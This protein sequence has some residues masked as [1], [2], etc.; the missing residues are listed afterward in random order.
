MRGGTRDGRTPNLSAVPLPPGPSAGGDHVIKWTDKWAERLLHD[1]GREQWG[2]KWR[3]EFSQGAGSKNGEVWDVTA[4]GH[5]YQRWWGEDHH[6]DGRVR[7]HGHSTGGEWWDDTI[8]MD[9]YYNPIPHFGYKH[10]LDHSPQLKRVP[11]RPK[12]WP[13]PAGG[14]AAT[15]ADD[16]PFG[17]GLDDL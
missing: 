11:L 2:D 6:G 17:G 10:A 15:D 5:R 1:G 13:P 9:T 16:N 3:E 7:R 4:G 14:K 8:H 12:H